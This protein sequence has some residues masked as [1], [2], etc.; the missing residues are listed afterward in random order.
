MVHE[1][2]LPHIVENAPPI[3]TG[4]RL[5]LAVDPDTLDPE[6]QKLFLHELARLVHVHPDIFVI[7]KLSE[8]EQNDTEDDEAPEQPPAAR[9]GE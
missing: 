2:T 9:A 1:L 7:R 5:E 3:N 6:K 4:V 8:T